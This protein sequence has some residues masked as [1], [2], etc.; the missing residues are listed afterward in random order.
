MTYFRGTLRFGD[1]HG[2]TNESFQAM[3]AESRSLRHHDPGRGGDPGHRS[4]GG[5]RRQLRHQ[6][7]GASAS[8]TDAGG[9]VLCT[10]DSSGSN[11]SSSWTMV[12]AN[13]G[14]GW[15]Q[16][17]TIYRWGYGS[18]VK[19]WAQQNAGGSTVN[20]YA[21]GCSAVGDT[22]S[23]WQQLVFTSGGWRVQSNMNS[24]IIAQSSFNPISSWALPF[25]VS[26]EGETIYEASNVPG[27]SSSKQNFTNMQVQL[28]SD[29]SWVSTCNNTSLLGARESTR[30]D[31]DRPWCNN[32]RMWTK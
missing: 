30:Y 18:C 29:N 10:G 11:N 25:S 21:G 15:A 4:S 27:T 16:S 6:L 20:Y 17:G 14:N 8:I 26:F 19:H 7:E 32:V 24:T 23:Y 2:G 5:P 9:Y 13:D 28:W 3:A 31:F 12:S 22:N 1:F